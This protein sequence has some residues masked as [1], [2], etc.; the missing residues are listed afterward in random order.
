MERWWSTTPVLCGGH[1]AESA[2]A[3][4]VHG[5]QRARAGGA[6]GQD[7]EGARGAGGL[8]GRLRQEPRGHRGAGG[9]RAAGAVPRQSGRERPEA[10]ER[11]ARRDAAASRDGD[12]AGGHAHPGLG[13]CAHEGARWGAGRTSTWGGVW[14]TVLAVQRLLEDR[15]KA[16]KIEAKLQK[17]YDEMKVRAEYTEVRIVY[18]LSMRPL[19]A[20]RGSS[21]KEKEKKLRMLSDQKRRVEN[22]NALLETHMENFDRYRVKKM[23][24]R[25]RPCSVGVVP[26]SHVV[27]PCQKIVNELARSHAFY[28]AK[29]LELFAFPCQAIAKLH[30]TETTKLVTQTNPADAS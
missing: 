21:A 2:G 11:H 22:V 8:S 3:A 29:G 4:A 30:P 19:R 23:K 24:V 6:S 13:H 16:I 9:V 26:S 28:Y 27:K 12:P 17:E 5:A 10:G 1:G 14:L 18:S 7:D 20:Q 25:R 15:E